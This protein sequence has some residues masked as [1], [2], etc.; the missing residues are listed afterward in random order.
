M[1]FK[2]SSVLGRTYTIISNL[3]VS[4]AKILTKGT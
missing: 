2:N 4:N 1:Q 3:E